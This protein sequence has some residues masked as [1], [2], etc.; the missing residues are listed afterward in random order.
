[1]GQVKRRDRLGFYVLLEKEVIY[2][3]YRK[4]Q[5]RIA[6]SCGLFL[7]RVIL[8]GIHS[9]IIIFSVSF[10]ATFGL[11]FYTEQKAENPRNKG[12]RSRFRHFLKSFAKGNS[13]EFKSC[14]SD[15]INRRFR[16]FFIFRVI[17]RVIF[18][19]FPIISP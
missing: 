4:P 9:K 13:F 6:L 11:K 7:C 16:R 18:F 1:M 14:H 15:S 8:C 12:K 17:L 2:L 5:G 3:N 10:F 19:M